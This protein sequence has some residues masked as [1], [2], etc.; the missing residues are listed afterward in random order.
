[1]FQSKDTKKK[2]FNSSKILLSFLL[3]LWMFIFFLFIF[4]LPATA[5]VIFFALSLPSINYVYCFA[6]YVFCMSNQTE[7]KEPQPLLAKKIEW[8]LN[9]NQTNQKKRTFFYCFIFILICFF[10]KFQ[11]KWVPT[12]YSKQPRKN[13]E[14]QQNTYKKRFQSQFRIEIVK[15][16]V[17]HMDKPQKK[18]VL[19]M[20]HP[21]SIFDKFL[22]FINKFHI[23]K[24]R[25]KHTKIR[26]KELI[27]NIQNWLLFYEAPFLFPSY[28]SDF[29]WFNKCYERTFLWKKR[30]VCS[31]FFIINF[32][33]KKDK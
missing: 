9:N 17:Q 28:P 5:S 1:M 25:Q 4:R 14:F 31:Q 8:K 23:R 29:K 32:Q 3:L 10:W 24:K 2:K 15:E 26:Q 13:K 18:Y 19:H 6:L 27:V 7:N 33:K 22:C 21:R 12:I 11:Y 20:L 30:C 16:I